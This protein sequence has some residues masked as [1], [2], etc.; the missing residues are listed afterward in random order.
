MNDV[1]LPRLRAASEEFITKLVNAGY[2]Q[3]ALRNDPNAITTAIAELK[4]DLRG[5]RQDGG[6]EAA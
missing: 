3:S 1:V 4:E 2:L 6:P 5:G